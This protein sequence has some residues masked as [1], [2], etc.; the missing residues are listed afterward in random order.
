[1]TEPSTGIE[2]DLA[3][4]MRL[5]ADI[6]PTIATTPATAATACKMASGR[7][8]ISDASTEKPTALASVAMTATPD[9]QI[10]R[11]RYHGLKSSMLHASLA[12]WWF[13]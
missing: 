7:A 2:E 4:P 13:S 6:R 5:R 12:G 1:M 8:A 9:A 11:E 3:A 10:V